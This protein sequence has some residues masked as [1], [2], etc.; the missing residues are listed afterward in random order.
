MFR[1]PVTN[2]GMKLPIPER[3]EN[4][5][6]MFAFHPSVAKE[7]KERDNY[8][9]LCGYS[10]RDGFKL[11]ASHKNHDKNNPYY[12]HIDN[13]TTLCVECHLREHIALLQKA[14]DYNV[15]WAWHSVRLLA[16]NV[17]DDSFHTKG[18]RFKHKDTL[19]EDREK[20][21]KIFDDY[22]LDVFEFITV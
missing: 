15:N 20:V 16:Q 3:S 14:D 8:T 12:N 2:S 11:H 6:T 5:F 22:E 4:S 18:W 1:E 21:V 17:W 13:G 19:E 9:C 7:I 10:K